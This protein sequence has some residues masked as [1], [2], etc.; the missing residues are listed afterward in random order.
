MFKRRWYLL[1]KKVETGDLRLYALDR[2]AS[3]QL[4]D[5]RFDY[6]TDF[7]PEV[8]FANYFGVSTDGYTET[9]CRVVLR[10]YHELPRY[11]ESQPLHPSQEIAD[12]GENYTDFSY[13]LIPAFDFVQEILLHCEQ[14]EVVSPLSLRQHVAEILQKSS[15]FYK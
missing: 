10:A 7:E 4:T 2:I 8:Y 3:C 9:P 11:I 13:N 1:S 14:L 6:P 5:K 15:E 12:K